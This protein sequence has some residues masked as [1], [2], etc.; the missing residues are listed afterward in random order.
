VSS[1]H[2]IA[3]YVADEKITVDTDGTIAQHSTW[4]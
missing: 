1:G 2:A 4:R 3:G